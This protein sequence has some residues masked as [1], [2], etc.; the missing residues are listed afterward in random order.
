MPIGPH[1]I[2]YVNT[3]YE[4]RKAKKTYWINKGCSE[5]KAESLLYRYGY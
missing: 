5:S 4:R 1:D 3:K 2:K